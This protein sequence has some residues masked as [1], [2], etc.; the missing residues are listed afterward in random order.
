MA[1]PRDLRK[2]EPHPVAALGTC[3]DLAKR[4]VV[5]FALSIH[6]A[7]EIELVRHNMSNAREVV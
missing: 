4:S 6:E 7:V 3:S 5:G 2:D 1:E